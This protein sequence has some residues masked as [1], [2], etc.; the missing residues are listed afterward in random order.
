MHPN[1]QN[2]LVIRAIEDADPSAFG[3]THVG[4]PE[5]VMFQLFLAR[6]LEARN[7][8][9]RGSTPDMTWAIAPSLPAVSIP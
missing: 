8:A 3:K 7:F 1:H 2:F 9:A 4:T 6:L 5:E